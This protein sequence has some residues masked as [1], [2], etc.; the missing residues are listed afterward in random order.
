M[1]GWFKF[2][3]KW[4]DNGV[5]SRDSDHL[6]VWVYLHAHAVFEKQQTVIGSTPVILYPGQLVT[7]RRMIAQ[8]MYLQ[9]S[10]VTR[11]LNLFQKA[12]LIEQQTTPFA[13][14]ITLLDADI[15]QLCKRKDEKSEQPSSAG[16][17][18]N[19]GVSEG[20]DKRSEQRLNNGRTTPEQRLNTYKECKNEKNDNNANKKRRVCKTQTRKDAES[21]FFG[22]ASYDLAAFTRNAIGLEDLDRP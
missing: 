17:A 20:A 4:L 12:G 13:R 2:E 3:R 22:E 16:K 15:E 7:G 10:R 8:S 18:P 1:E 21:I 9:E 6:A 14:I 19:D 5:I 11:I